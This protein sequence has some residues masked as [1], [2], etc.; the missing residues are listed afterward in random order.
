MAMLDAP[1]CP[2]LLL[3]LSPAHA[4]ALAVFLKR[5]GWSEWRS[6][7]VDETEAYSIRAACE[8]LR[9]ELARFGFDPR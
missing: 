9:G 6:L 1:A 5:V 2:P 4:E 3:E 7:A 8:S